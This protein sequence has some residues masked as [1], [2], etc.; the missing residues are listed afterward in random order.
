VKARTQVSKASERIMM[1]LTCCYV[2]SCG[3]FLA[4]LLS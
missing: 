1:S 4:A 2:M 3:L